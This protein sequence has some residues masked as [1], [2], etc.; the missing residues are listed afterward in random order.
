MKFIL[1]LLISSLVGVNLS[2][3]SI[4]ASSPKKRNV[5]KVKVVRY[6]QKRY[7]RKRVVVVRQRRVSTVRGL[8]RNSTRLSFRARNYHFN[9]GIYYLSTGRGYQVVK[10]PVGLRIKRLP[11]STVVVKGPK[12]KYWF[13]SGTYYRISSAN[14]GYEVVEPE[15][16]LVVPNIP[17]DHYEEVKVDGNRYLACNDILYVEVRTNGRLNYRIAGFVD[18]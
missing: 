8:P 5:K 11:A 14:D 17:R 4:G 9:N 7:P 2:T 12:T 3:A 13:H 6:T 1:A 10:A 15:V 18:A 16:G